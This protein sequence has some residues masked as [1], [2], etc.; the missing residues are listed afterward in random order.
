VTPTWRAIKNLGEIAENLM[1]TI[2]S[3]VIEIAINLISYFKSFIS[4]T[5]RSCLRNA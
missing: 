5:L 2:S 3:Q 4:Q 1:C